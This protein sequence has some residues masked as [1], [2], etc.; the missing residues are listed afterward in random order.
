MLSRI[1]FVV[2]VAASPVLR[3]VLVPLRGTGPK[4]LRPR[5]AVSSSHICH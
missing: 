4:V 2:G 5:A 1:A 3:S